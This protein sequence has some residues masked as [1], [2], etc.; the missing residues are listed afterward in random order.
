VAD[1]DANNTAVFKTKT[2]SYNMMKILAELTLRFVYRSYSPKKNLK[3][4][5][6]CWL[7]DWAMYILY[8]TEIMRSLRHAATYA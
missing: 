8:R 6:L 5:S 3:T 2:E 1:R 7:P 4:V